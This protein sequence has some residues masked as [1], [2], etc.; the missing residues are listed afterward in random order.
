MSH[1]QR[2]IEKLKS[3]IEPAVT[4]LKSWIRPGVDRLK[5]IG[6]TRRLFWSTG[7]KITLGGVAGAVS[8]LLVYY[9]ISGGGLIGAPDSSSLKEIHSPVREIPDG[10]LAVVQY[11]PEGDLDRVI[12][13]RE[14]VVTF[15]HPMVP[16]AALHADP[17]S[18]QAPVR[19]SP[20]LPGRFRW[21]GS[22]SAAFIPDSPLRPAE[23]YTVTIPAGT[24]SIDGRVLKKGFQFTFRTPVLEIENS[25][26]YNGSTF[27][28]KQNF[29]LKFNYEVDPVRIQK[30][31]H[32]LVNGSEVPFR[33][34]K[35]TAEERS[36][37]YF[38]YD[39]P[40]G[41]RG[42]SLDPASDFPRGARISLQS[43]SGLIGRHRN[44][45]TEPVRME[46][47]T[48]GPLKATFRGED[49]RFFQY[50]W[51]DGIQFNNPVRFRDA[52]QKIQISPKVSYQ[53][54][55]PDRE[56]TTTHFSLGHFPLKPETDY[57][58]RIAPGLRDA[59]GNPFQGEREFHYRTPPYRRDFSAGVSMAVLEKGVHGLVPVHVAGIESLDAEIGSFGVDA[60]L[61]FAQDSSYSSSI[62]T[63]RLTN[64]PWSTG[65]QRNRSGNVAFRLEN[66]LSQRKLN[67]TGWYA[68]TLA[69]TVQEYDGDTVRRKQTAIV[70]VTDMGMVAKRGSNG[71]HVWLH[72]LSSG[73]AIAGSHVEYHSG[74]RQN[75]TC[76]S[77]GEGHCFIKAS[78]DSDPRNDVII[79]T[80]ADGKDRVFIT[81]KQDQFSMW[82]LTGNFDRDA[83]Q[84]ALSGQI[85]FDRK[86]YIPGDTV[87][88]R[89][90][91][92]VRHDGNL[93]YE[94]GKLGTIKVEINNA[95]GEKMETL[96]LNASDE[97]FVGGSFQ[98]PEEMPT[99][100]QT[101]SFHSSRA[102]GSIRDTFQVEEFKP[103]RFSVETEL[104]E[105]Q[106]GHAT[107]NGTV[108][109]RYLFGGP[110]P[111]AKV[112]YSWSR[113]PRWLS[114]RTRPGYRFGDDDYSVQ[115]DTP[116]WDRVSGGEGKL[117]G[118]GN[119]SVPVNGSPMHPASEGEGLN[120]VYDLELEARVSDVDDRS[121]AST[122]NFTVYPGNTLPGIQVEERYIPAGNRFHLK[123][124]A[125]TP[126]G[127]EAFAQGKIVVEK[128]EWKTVMTRSAGGSVQRKNSLTRKRILEQGVALAGDPVSF[129][130][131]AAEPGNYVVTVSV[132]ETGAYSRTNI[133]AY[134]GGYVGWDFRNDD[135][136]ELL[137]DR[138]EYAPG[139]TAKV[140][141]QSPFPECT[142]IVTVER[143]GVMWQK[144]FHLKG[145]GT[146]IEIPITEKHVPDVFVGVLLLRPRITNQLT[147]TSLSSGVV[148]HE[149]LGRPVLKAGMIR[150]SVDPSSR[151]IPLTV[152]SDRTD[153]GPGDDVEL[154][155]RSAPGA[156]VVLS[157]AD[158]GVLDLVNYRFEDPLHAFYGS[159]P[160]GVSILENRHAI[161]EL[162]TYAAKGSAPGGKGWGAEAAGQ[163][164]FDRDSEDGARREFRYTAH[165][166]SSLSVGSD[167]TAKLKFKLPHNLTTFRIQGLAARGGRYNH[168]SSEFRV[169]KP[170]VLRPVLPGFFRP[171]DTVE[172]GGV[173]TNQSGQAQQFT[174]KLES[175]LLE[176]PSGSVGTLQVEP[177]QT[178]EFSVPVRINAAAYAKYRE[179][180]IRKKEEHP[181]EGEDSPYDLRGIDAKI[182][183]SVV[184]TGSRANDASLKDAL[185]SR[186]PVRESPPVEAFAIGGISNGDE[187]EGIRIPEQGSVADGLGNFQLELS[188]TAMTGIGGAFSF[189][190]TNPYFCTEQLASAFLVRLSAGE[191][192]ES[193]GYEHPSGDGYDFDTIESR[194]IR[195]LRK[196]QNRDGGF[197][198]W[199]S[200]LSRS[201]PYLSAYVT[202]V[203][204]AARL[205]NKR[206][207]GNYDIPDGIYKN[208][209]NYLE[210]YAQK[211]EKDSWRYAL[212][213]F[214][215][216]QLVLARED[217]ASEGLESFLFNHYDNLSYRGR[218]RLAMARALRTGKSANRDKQIKRIVR[219]L[220]N[221]LQIQT[222]GVNFAGDLP[223]GRAFGSGGST[224]AETLRLFIA[225]KPDS[226]L[227]PKMV[228]RVVDSNGASLWKSSHNAG[229]LAYA[230]LDYR[231]RFESKKPDFTAKVLLDKTELVSQTFKGRSD[232]SM[233]KRYS[234]GELNRLAG[235][236]LDRTLSFIKEGEGILY[237]R[238]LLRYV[239]GQ[240][241]DKPRDEGIEVRREIL[242][243]SAVGK[244]GSSMELGVTGSEIILERGKVYL[245]RMT[246]SNAMPVHNFALNDPLPSTSEV[247][248][249]SFA[250]EGNAYSRILQTAGRKE[251]DDYFWWMDEPARTEYRTDRVVI[252]K[253]YLSPG[254]HE[255][256][257]LIRPLVRGKT[258]WPG[259]RGWAM[260][261]P[262]IFGRSG[263]G[264]VDVR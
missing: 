169:R 87:H 15:S 262:E 124:V 245:V 51:S 215:L 155:V 173:V 139:D 9:G 103:A 238:A 120:R 256:Y 223:L 100:H 92:A 144:S 54:G 225:L 114:F 141:I 233:T 207:N 165:W 182:K 102:E 115:W 168:A 203:L 195:S 257:Y 73:K 130:F 75:G 129:D 83:A 211:P 219:D 21:Y 188:S 137:A 106:I 213:T 140:M 71:V 136:V 79:A 172:A 55:T 248:Q 246:V 244:S 191:L 108:R 220:E 162:A 181:G 2:I 70:Q 41:Q 145:N 239:P 201:D 65:L 160:L 164:G 1:F 77:D 78:P 43:R 80:A 25:S 234:L 12:P 48:Y 251:S 149:D 32:L 202:Y 222:S 236:I 156:E 243:L 14:I 157:V 56:Q 235:G 138:E 131:E 146:P 7:G 132:P 8:L 151:R 37:S 189:F 35:T 28:Y 4:R 109:G 122:G 255:F 186:V 20:D 147:E 119:L 241:A 117:D 82:G 69:G 184:P 152:T 125:V 99:G 118:A 58:I 89:A 24:R 121:V 153:Y 67:T 88:Y 60:V 34:R 91:L 127:E 247:V 74:N 13:G 5:A 252:T 259:A 10:E 81:G 143:E 264:S 217:R 158:R 263:Y 26:P 84:P 45:K 185:I 27:A 134:G 42:V 52:L 72:S 261:E 205:E 61:D 258:A 254:A 178:A 194:F 133:Y 38:F 57:T 17:G 126:D 16:L 110:M 240:S 93:E 113:R 221:N 90:L 94:S 171:G 40:E 47:Q 62:S 250:T 163:G 190:A 212:E 208:A 86:L 199:E 76:T 30:E 218:A 214:A 216:I 229:L 96:S 226:P 36:R 210:G 101:I 63:S 198:F 105:R 148:R 95:R 111:G 167:G 230:L 174:I 98:L 11:S 197:R 128:K 180:E 33:I 31:L 6:W 116:S 85:V 183:L 159:W 200:G 161:I 228:R 176:F 196:V 260:Y 142:A 166:E 19:I 206:S 107:I 249:A 135:I 39:D 123:L 204:Q 64:F 104:P 150:L 170:V 44:G 18:I 231:I 192:L 242:P 253:E 193:F 224:L 112:T 154:T 232:G 68:I 3:R 46:F 177:D 29:I 179:E 227:I 23:R 175:D 22:R 49:T 66:I 59:Y 53:G 97:G 50:R 237:Y 209:L 187:K